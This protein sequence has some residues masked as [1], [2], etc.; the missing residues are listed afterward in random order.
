[1]NIS[2]FVEVLDDE[3]PH[4]DFI[5]FDACFMMSIEVHM[6]YVI[7]LIIIWDVLRKILD[8]GLLMIK[9]CL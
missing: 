4:F 7:I 2:D 5:M 1:M 3:M 9:L 6:Q 8:R